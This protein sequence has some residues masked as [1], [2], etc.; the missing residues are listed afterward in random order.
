MTFNQFSQVVEFL[1]NVV[2]IFG[3]LGI[4]GYVYKIEIYNKRYITIVIYPYLI[5]EQ[6]EISKDIIYPKVGKIRQ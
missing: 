3:F 5:K 6:F 4:G 2:T 1:A